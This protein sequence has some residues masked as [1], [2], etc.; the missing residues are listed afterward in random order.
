MQQSI[1]T[2]DQYKDL[3][4][5]IIY[6]VD[7][8]Y[9]IIPLNSLK[10][11]KYH[12]KAPIYVTLEFEEDKVI[13]SFDDIE[14]FSYADTTSEAIDSLSDEIIQIFEDLMEDKENLGSLPRKW[15]Q[16][17]EEIIECR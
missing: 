17:L 9:R 10:H 14:A 2:P 13:A 12:L 1:L 16:Y 11:P 6:A 5:K 15:L 4:K 7:T 8:R 3:S